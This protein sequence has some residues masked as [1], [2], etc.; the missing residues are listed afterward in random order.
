LLTE[1]VSI[2]NLLERLDE[3]GLAW[4][5]VF[6]VVAYAGGW[7]AARLSIRSLTR[8]VRRTK[9]PVDDE[10]IARVSRPVRILLPVLAVELALPLLPLAQGLATG[11]RQVAQVALVVVSGWLLLAVIRETEAVLSSRYDPRAADDASARSRYTQVRA[12]GNISRFLVVVVTLAFALMSIDTLRHL[13]AGLLASAGIAGVVLGFAAQK[14]LGT[15]LAGIQLAVT[16]PIRVD[17]EVVVEGEW[18]RIEE[19]TL[20]YVVVRTWD[21]RRLILPISQFIDKPFQNWTRSSTE[22]LGTVEL[23]LDYSVSVDEIR[24][25]FNRILEASPS[26]DRKN[27]R[28]QVTD[29]TD[30]AM[31]VRLVVSAKNSGA[32]F[33]LRCDVRE[34][35]IAYVQRHH[36]NALPRT[37][38]DIRSEMPSPEA[39]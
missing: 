34:K 14:S 25:E 27:S 24:A 16:Q 8:I 1:H 32:L 15:I 38:A 12:F 11:L 5:L 23:H 26:W 33:D 9:T 20:S 37:R 21:L 39:R 31:L 28:V 17:D 29:S 36:P 18:G 19:I 2:G 35:L 13:G 22:L 6:L 3:V 10:A 7:L 30:H 4:S